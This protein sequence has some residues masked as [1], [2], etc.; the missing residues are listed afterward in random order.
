M[1]KVREMIDAWG[2]AELAR[3]L[4]KPYTT[5]QTWRSDGRIPYA[6]WP[7]VAESSAGTAR[8]VTVREIFD[9]HESDRTEP[10]EPQ[11]AAEAAE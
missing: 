4:G 6:M 5:V 11:P 2:A 7:S 9:A 10:S 3:I 8:V 1:S